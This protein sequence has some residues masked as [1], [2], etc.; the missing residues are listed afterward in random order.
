MAD[1]LQQR[2][3]E[4]IRFKPTPLQRRVAA[5]IKFSPDDGRKN[6]AERLL[7]VLV[8]VV[9][10]VLETIDKS[11]MPGVEATKDALKRLPRILDELVVAIGPLPRHHLVYWKLAELMLAMQFMPVP[12][13]TIERILMKHVQARGVAKRTTPEALAAS[14]AKRAEVIKRYIPM[15]A[16]ADDRCKGPATR[17]ERIKQIWD[18]LPKEEREGGS[19]RI[20]DEALSLARRAQK[21]PRRRKPRSHIAKLSVAI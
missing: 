10:P 13:D 8:K 18:L 20:V 14:A 3:A 7:D 15:V 17:W 16:T 9:L 12:V 6:V 11:E 5:M 21:K 2:D 1:H 4:P 19:L